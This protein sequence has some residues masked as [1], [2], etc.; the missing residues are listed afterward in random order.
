MDLEVVHAIAPG[1]QLV[2]YTQD[3]SAVARSARSDQDFLGALVSFQDRSVRENPRADSRAAISLAA[4][5]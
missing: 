3:Q 5:M 1:A 2:L 4:S